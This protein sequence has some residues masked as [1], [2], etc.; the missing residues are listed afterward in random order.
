MADTFDA[1][2]SATSYVGNVGG[3][4]E[5][6]LPTLPGSSSTPQTVRLQD[7]AA[8]I[9][10]EAGVIITG[11]RYLTPPSELAELTFLQEGT[12]VIVSTSSSNDFDKNATIVYFTQEVEDEPVDEPQRTPVVSSINA[13]SFY[14]GEIVSINGTD[15]HLVEQI[16]F[17]DGEDSIYNLSIAPDTGVGKYNNITFTLPDTFSASVPDG[18]MRLSGSDMDDIDVSVSFYN[19]PT[20]TDTDPTT[21]SIGSPIEITGTNLGGITSVTA[22]LGFISRIAV[23]ESNNGTTMQIHFND[24]FED[25]ILRFY[26]EIELK[27]TGTLINITGGA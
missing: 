25:G 20:V 5:A 27:V 12:S 16:D 10:L 11:V 22:F 13:E 21:T 18:T 24:T 15:L 14:V 26:S 19:A 2:N 6:T 4:I 8:A 1:S 7:G 9:T 3:T 17:L 23:I